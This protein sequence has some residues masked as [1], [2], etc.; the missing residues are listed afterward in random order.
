MSH[1]KLKASSALT[2]EILHTNIFVK[3]TE[4]QQNL[5]FHLYKHAFRCGHIIYRKGRTGLL[6]MQYMKQ[7]SEE[8]RIY[9]R[10]LEAKVYFIRK[11]MFCLV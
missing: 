6:F 8:N 11:F 7:K 10:P 5:L 3:L 1:K 4:D 9:G 2:D